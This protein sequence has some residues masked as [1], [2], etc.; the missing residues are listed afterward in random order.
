[1]KQQRRLHAYQHHQRPDCQS[2]ITWNQVCALARHKPAMTAFLWQNFINN[3]YRACMLLWNPKKSELLPKSI[4]PVKINWLIF[5]CI[6]R[7]GNKKFAEIRAGSLSH[8]AATPCSLC[9]PTR[10]CS[11]A[12][13][14]RGTQNPIKKTK[15]WLWPLNRCEL[16][17]GL[18][19][20]YFS[21]TI[22]GLK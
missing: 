22:L 14:R 3:V 15:R 20:L 7:V 6:F 4:L 18:Y 12:M 11:Q 1:M 17:I 5:F 21:E 2:K 16:L 9:A 8:L 10:A 13:I 19:S